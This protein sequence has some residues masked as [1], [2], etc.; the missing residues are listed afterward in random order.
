[1]PTLYLPVLCSLSS[2][3]IMATPF[4]SSSEEALPLPSP[5]ALPSTAGTV[6]ALAAVRDDDDDDDD[7]EEKAGGDGTELTKTTFFVVGC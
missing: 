3:R 7:D 2:A 4:S 1:M 6:D 5:T